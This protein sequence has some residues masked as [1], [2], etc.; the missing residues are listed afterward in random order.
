MDYISD[1]E[2]NEIENC[3]KIILK[4]FTSEDLK[5]DPSFELNRSDFK[6]FTEFLKSEEWNFEEIVIGIDTFD[7]NFLKRYNYTEINE[8][9]QR[10]I[11][12][13]FFYSIIYK[14]GV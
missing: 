10:M 3:L 8:E 6:T 14:T 4:E 2:N 5:E 9:E 12:L 7:D 1:I 11:K 13:R